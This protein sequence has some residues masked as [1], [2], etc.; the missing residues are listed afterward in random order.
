MFVFKNNLCNICLF[1]IHFETKKAFFQIDGFTLLFSAKYNF[2]KSFI[3]AIKIPHVS[4]CDILFSLQCCLICRLLNK[5]R[6]WQ[7]KLMRLDGCNFLDAAPQLVGLCPASRTLG[8]KLCKCR[9][10]ESIRKKMKM[11]RTLVAL[12]LGN[13]ALH[14][15]SC[16]TFGNGRK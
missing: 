3:L 16:N 9:Q 8:R 14:Q 13:K 4:P 12:G 11:K 5:T 10:L 2:L 15:N 7:V 1:C 6:L